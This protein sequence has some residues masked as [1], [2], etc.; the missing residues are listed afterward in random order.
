MPGQ[1]GASRDI[2]RDAAAAHQAGDTAT[3]IRLYREFL[4]DYPDAAEIRS[5]LAA[6]L[7]E[8]GKFAEAIP[9][10]NAVLRKL[11]NNPRVRMNLALAYYTLGR[12]PEPVQ[13]L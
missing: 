5:N 11:Q 9:E 12:L 4:K 8:D 2:L 1:T 7:L 3:A 6:A 10:Y 13:D